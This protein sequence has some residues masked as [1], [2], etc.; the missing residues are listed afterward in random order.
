MP[1]E[2]S[3]PVLTPERGMLFFYSGIST[4]RPRI[5]NFIRH[6]SQRDPSFHAAGCA[7]RIPTQAGVSRV[8]FSS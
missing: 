3:I 2:P 8:I 7:P 6:P 1:L 5:N 4:R